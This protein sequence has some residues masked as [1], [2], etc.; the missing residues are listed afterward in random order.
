MGIQTSEIVKRANSIYK[1]Y[2]TR[3]PYALADVMNI[4]ILPHKFKLQRG[5]YKVILNNRFIFIKDDLSPVME[6]IV[7]LHEIGHD[8]LHRHE[9]IANGGFKEFNIFDMRQNRMEYEAN[10]FASQ[11]SLPDD[12][13][14]EYIERGYDIQQIAGA[15]HSD[16]NL[17]ALKNDTLISQGYRFRPQ[18]HRSDFLKYDI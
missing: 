14:L 4:T 10:I 1:K 8:V 7:L 18:E 13:I 12:E 15:M 16:I 9:A 6:K 2:D 17:V 3:N 5:A 11:I